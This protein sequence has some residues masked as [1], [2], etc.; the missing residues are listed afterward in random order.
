MNIEIDMVAVIQS[1]ILRQEINAELRERCSNFRIVL[2][3]VDEI[4]SEVRA[5]ALDDGNYA[6]VGYD[7]RSETTPESTE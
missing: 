1:D 6:I 5:R 7:R 4:K 3:S 2:L